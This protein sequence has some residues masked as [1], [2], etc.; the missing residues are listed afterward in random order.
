MTMTHVQ[1]HNQESSR[2]H[3]DALKIIESQKTL[4]AVVCR[5]PGAR[6]VGR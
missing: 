1:T 2:P 5:G 4:G 6:R 3:L